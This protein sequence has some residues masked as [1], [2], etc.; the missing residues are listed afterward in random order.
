MARQFFIYILSSRRRV[1]YV[2]VT[3][4]LERRLLEHQSGLNGGFTTRYR[5]NQLVYFETTENPLAAIE[6]EKEIKSWRRSKK[7][8]LITRMNPAWADLSRDWQ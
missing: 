5:A 1:L 3:N 8:Q 6:R 2:G 4:N 7:L